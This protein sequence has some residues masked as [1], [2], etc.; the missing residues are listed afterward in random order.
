MTEH[1]RN[2]LVTSALP[3]ANGSIH[4]GHLVEYIQTDI[5]VRFQKM[6]GHCVYY[7]CADDAHGTPIMLRAQQENIS[8]EELIE[9]VSEEHQRDFADFSVEFDNYHTTHS[10]ENQLISNQTS[11]DQ[12]SKSISKSITVNVSL[13]EH[14]VQ[15]TN[16]K[17]TLFIFARSVDGPRMPIAVVRKQMSD[18]PLTVVLDDSA[19]MMEQRRL[20][21]FD[22]VVVSA[23]ISRT[24]DAMP[25]QGDLIGKNITVDMMQTGSVKILIDQKVSLIP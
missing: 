14:L 7:V 3:Y 1:P 13:S 18:L 21:R 2:I 22:K 20:S 17:D 12:V 11:D 25:Q 16:P 4:I 19:S 15:D 5:W 9:R 10:E 23:R 24:G 6:Q 8:P